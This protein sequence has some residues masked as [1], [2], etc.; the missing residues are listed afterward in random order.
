MTERTLETLFNLST[1]LVIGGVI[2]EA[3]DHV[4][5]FRE[6]GLRPLRPK[7]GS[8]ILVL[9]LCGELG[10]G[11]R[12]FRIATHARA[13]AEE[14]VARL[15]RKTEVLRRANSEISQFVQPRRLTPEQEANFGMMI[16]H[17]NQRF[18]LLVAGN[19]MEAV[20]LAVQ[21]R[22]VLCDAGW[23]GGDI[24]GNA[25]LAMI[26]VHVAHSTDAPMGVRAAQLAWVLNADKLQPAIDISGDPDMDGL[27]QVEGDVLEIR[28]GAKPLPN[29]GDL[30]RPCHAG[31][32]D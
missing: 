14:R 6:S 20:M 32:A 22:D 24:I 15:N 25:R 4:E 8:A 30:G 2:L 21:L 18:R 5:K 13:Q 10:A 11:V 3:W 1:V 9:G 29:A 7:I 31:D 23:V 28:I 26:G 12:L 17:P 19:D 16:G 27:P